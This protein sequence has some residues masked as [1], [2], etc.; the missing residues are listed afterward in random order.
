MP[1]QGQIV[2]LKGPKGKGILLPTPDGLKVKAADGNVYPIAQENIPEYLTPIYEKE[3]LFRLTPDEMTLK[4]IS[5][6]GGSHLM[7]F[8]GFVPVNQDTGLPEARLKRGGKVPPY[9]DRKTGKKKPGFFARDKQQFTAMNEIVSGE[10]EGLQVGW[11][12]DYIFVPREGNETGWAGPAKEVEALEQ[13]LR[14]AGIDFAVDTLPYNVVNVLPAL[15]AL[16][17]ERDAIFQGVIEEGNIATVAA[18][19]PGLVPTHVKPRKVVVPDE[20]EE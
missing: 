4:G 3:V 12:L 6:W 8:A 11:F 14:A 15:Q 18:L 1:M 20:D 13:F 7:R 5:P 16:L 2:V 17:I 19:A 9:T 10:Y